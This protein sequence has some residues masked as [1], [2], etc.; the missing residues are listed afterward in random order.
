MFLTAGADTKQLQPNS[1][2]L[3]TEATQQLTAQVIVPACPTVRPK[4]AGDFDSSSY[5]AQ[6]FLPVCI[7]VQAHWTWWSRWIPRLTII[8]L[9]SHYYHTGAES[10][11]TAVEFWKS[12]TM[13]SQ[14]AHF[15]CRAR[16]RRGDDVRAERRPQ[17]GRDQTLQRGVLGVHVVK[18]PSF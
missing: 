5:P 1:R 8:S 17:G 6:L 2:I 15:Q 3:S 12:E 13:Y 7:S 16:A 4:A 14:P 18:F 11:S 10:S 9:T